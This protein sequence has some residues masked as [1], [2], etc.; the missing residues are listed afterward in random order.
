LF[1]YAT[2]PLIDTFLLYQDSNNVRK[3]IGPDLLLMEDCF[4]APS[5][6][7][8][9]TRLPPRCV[10]E[11]TYPKSHFKDLESNVSFYFSLGIETYLVIDAITPQKKLRK[12]IK[13]HLWRKTRGKSYK[14]I[15]TDNAGYFLLPEMNVKITAQ[16]QRLIFAD[17]VTD[18]I[19][20]DSGQLGE[21][22]EE[23]EKRVEAEAQQAKIEAQR[24]DIAEKQAKIAFSDGIQKGRLTEKQKIASN[25]LAAGIEPTIIAKTTD[26]SVD[27]IAELSAGGLNL[28]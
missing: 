3:R 24:A 28:D 13:L 6:Y 27:E 1:F 15:K 12:S 5:A 25:L 11:T 23:S 9:K 21:A 22:L 14:K 17:A 19:L 7:D 16:Q 18:E 4:P 10:I 20:R 8:L 2:T 26:L